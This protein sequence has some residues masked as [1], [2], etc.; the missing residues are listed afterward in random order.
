ME[1]KWLEIVEPQSMNLI[2]GAKR[3]GKS[4]LAYWLMEQLHKKY[5][6]NAYVYGLP[7]AK[8]HLLPEFTDPLTTL[9]LPE[10]SIIIFDEA[11]REFHSRTPM[12]ADNKQ[13]DTIAGLVGQ[14]NIVALYITQMTRKLD[15]GI[16]GACDSIMWK[17]PSLL[18]MK[19]EREQFR[20][21]VDSIYHK[22]KK[23]EDDSIKMSTYVIS[24]DFE[25]FL[26][27]PVPDWWSEELST[28]YKGV[29]LVTKNKK[30][31]DSI[32]GIACYYCE[33]AAVEIKDGTSVCANHLKA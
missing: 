25:G 12:G 5:G 30:G 19:F 22:F 6:L 29:P 1:Q 27:N 17:K 31:L 7:E 28:A 33:E 4:V 14:K 8:W 24:E 15:V 26:V 10:D 11:Y 9:D 13:I 18:Q 2:A 23:L 21:E 3:T 16:V 32:D 20:R